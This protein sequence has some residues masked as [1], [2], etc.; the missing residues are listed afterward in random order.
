[1]ILRQLGNIATLRAAV[2]SSRPMLEA[3]RSRPR[4][5]ELDVVRSNGAAFTLPEFAV[6]LRAVRLDIRL[7]ARDANLVADLRATTE[8]P[9]IS[10]KQA[11]SER[12][13][14]LLRRLARAANW[15]EAFHVLQ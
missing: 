2:L 8:E 13:C 5:I 11:V 9:Y 1:M 10:S 7:S 4:A 15:F 12:E 14:V 6:A 3:Y